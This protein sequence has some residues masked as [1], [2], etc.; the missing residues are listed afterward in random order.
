VGA[1][2][3]CPGALNVVLL[4]PPGAGKGTQAERLSRTRKLPK[5]STGDILREAAQAGTEVGLAAKVTMEA[6]N[7][8]GDDIMISIVRNRLEQE[9]ARCGFV[10]DGF[11]RTVVQAMALD[12][13]VDGR[14]PKVV[15]DIVVPE[16]VLVQRLATRRICSKCGANAAPEGKTACGK[17]GGTLVTRVDDGIEIVRERLKIYM[18]QTRPLVEYYAGRTS[19]TSID[20]NQPPDVVTAAIDAALDGALEAHTRGALL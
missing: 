12:R 16:D 6:G 8:V 14:G 7:L 9:D 2:G 18:R 10:L 13:L 20:G 5:I 4:G 17:C 3:A 15:L 19:F 1:Q 11:P